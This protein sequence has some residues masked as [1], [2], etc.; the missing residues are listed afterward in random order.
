MIF[1]WRCAECLPAM[2]MKGS[3]GRLRV[4]EA[5][6]EQLLPPSFFSFAFSTACFESGERSESG[7]CFEGEVLVNGKVVRESE[8]L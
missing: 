2:V 8:R 5:E 4:R 7:S 6:E 1:G 3:W